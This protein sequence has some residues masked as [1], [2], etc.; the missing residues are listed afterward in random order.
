MG[1]DKKTILVITTGT[2]EIQIKKS[3]CKVQTDEE[4]MNFAKGPNDEKLYVFTDK[5]IP[6]YYM[7]S[8]ARFGGELIS[9]NPDFYYPLLDFPIVRPVIDN[10][11]ENYGEIDTIILVYTDQPSSEKGHHKDTLYFAE[12]LEDLIGDYCQKNHNQKIE[13][14]TFVVDKELVNI[15]Y[16][17]G[18]FEKSLKKDYDEISDENA[19]IILLAQGGIDQINQALTLKLIEKC[20]SLAMLQ[21][22][23]LKPV[24]KLDFPQKFIHNLTKHQIFS[25]IDHLEYGAALNLFPDSAKP[26]FKEESIPIKL[27][28]IAEARRNRLYHNLTRFFGVKNWKNDER[29]NISFIKYLTPENPIGHNENLQDLLGEVYYFK[30]CEYLSLIQAYA[31]NE[32][33]NNMIVHCSSFIEVFLQSIISSNSDYD[34]INNYDKH[35]GE[36]I[37]YFRHYKY[38]AKAI[39]KAGIPLFI[40]Y[41]YETIEDQTIHNLIR[42]FRSVFSFYSNKTNNKGKLDKLRNNIVHEGKGV[43]KEEGSIYAQMENYEQLINKW[44]NT[45]GLPKQNSFKSMNEEIKESI[46]DYFIS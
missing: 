15:D 21:K 23:E 20:P 36:I 26:T 18:Y 43:N 25:L 19:N 34:L 35:I 7:L 6:D 30:C 9:K 1:K 2:R 42:E 40:E 31:H 33:Y 28:L 5:D 11:I 29:D 37:K 32:N 38:N 17:Y 4:K 24:K 44:C 8:S 39:D 45:F 41:T 14:D 27:L 12:I 16:L 22:E 3:D 10:V 46:A 13:F